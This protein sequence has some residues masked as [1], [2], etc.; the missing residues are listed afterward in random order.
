M[1]KRKPQPTLRALESNL[2]ESECRL[3]SFLEY[4]V[5]EIISD[6]LALRNL[7]KDVKKN[8]AKFLVD[9]RLLSKRYSDSGCISKSQETR[10]DRN[11]VKKDAAEIVIGINARLKELGSDQVSNIDLK[12]EVWIFLEVPIECCAIWSISSFRQW[13]QFGNVIYS[14]QTNWLHL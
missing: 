8:L 14:K 10:G 4:N 6:S 7:S 13:H 12:H 5:E 2:E 9:S 11:D 1:E 3:R